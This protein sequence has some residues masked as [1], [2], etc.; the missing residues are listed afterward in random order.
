MIMD[1]NEYKMDIL[2]NIL[3]NSVAQQTSFKREE[4]MFPKSVTQ[5]E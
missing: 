4:T 5:Q 3:L 2:H 1:L